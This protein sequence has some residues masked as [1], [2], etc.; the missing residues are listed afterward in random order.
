[1]AERA[2]PMPTPQG[3]A[4]R[5]AGRRLVDHASF[6]IPG[7]V[8]LTALADQGFRFFSEIDFN[9]QQRS[10]IVV[11]GTTST[12]T[13]RAQ[14]DKFCHRIG[15]ISWREAYA[16]K[17]PQ[18]STKTSGN[19]TLLSHMWAIDFVAKLLDDPD[20]HV[21]FYV[22]PEMFGEQISDQERIAQKELGFLLA[23]AMNKK[24]SPNPQLREKIDI[25]LGV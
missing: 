7:R 4:M 3:E 25:V 5:F 14:Y 16:E 13:S 15:G 18:A 24:N 11:L 10:N 17:I 21:V 19:E 22:V 8:V 6:P 9:S 20:I 1:M 12:P 23:T 2:T